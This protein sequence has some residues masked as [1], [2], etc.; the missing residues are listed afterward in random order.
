MSHDV[1]PGAAVPREHSPSLPSGTRAVRRPAR[2]R[3]E[4]DPGPRRC[5]ARPP[6][7]PNATSPVV[8]QPVV[9]FALGYQGLG[10]VRIGAEIARP[11]RGGIRLSRSGVW[12]VLGRHG[13]NT[14]AERGASI[15]H[16]SRMP[17]SGRSSVSY[18]RAQ[19]SV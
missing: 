11:R 8:E 2:R 12:R 19:A 4:A 10:P 7:L 18:R 15:S 14:R 5:S 13:L 17:R 3:R 1:R 16:L 9:A 6:R